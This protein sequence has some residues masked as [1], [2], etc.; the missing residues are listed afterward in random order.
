MS[1]SISDRERELVRR[2]RA[3]D[4]H[5]AATLLHTHRPE[6]MRYLT[7]RAGSAA[8]DLLQDTYLGVLRSRSRFRGQDF[9]AFALAV[10]RRSVRN[11]RQLRARSEAAAPELDGLP[12]REPSAL[13]LIERR[14]VASLLDHAVAELPEDQR[15][16]LRLLLR[17][18]RTP[19]EIAL[20]LGV[21]LST[22]S[23]RLQRAR[24]R[25]GVALA[26][27]RL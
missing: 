1:G 5:A 6:L 14:E 8:E 3:G 7:R 17:A 18:D 15:S 4:M 19:A 23:T 21:S 27:I 9:R 12:A 16:C 2:W 26:S 24:L 10:A 13:A 20:E 25:L 22:V 11:R